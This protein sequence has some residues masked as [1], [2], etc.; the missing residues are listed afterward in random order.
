MYS[1]EDAKKLLAFSPELQ[2]QI[3]SHE[4]AIHALDHTWKLTKSP[5]DLRTS[6]IH[7]DNF[8]E[9]L[10][11][12]TIIKTGKTYSSELQLPSCI[13][14]MKNDS[15]FLK[16]REGAYR[17]LHEYRNRA[18]HHGHTPDESMLN[19]AVILMVETF[20]ELEGY[21]L[22]IEYFK[23]DENEQQ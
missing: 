11:K 2:I 3:T 12:S 5:L 10:F 16:K 7:I 6:I 15:R 18:Y 22:E 17:M 23:G 1:S 21:D 13:D 8:L 19:W 20:K 4:T 9:L 14:I